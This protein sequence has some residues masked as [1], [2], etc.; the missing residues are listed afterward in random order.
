MHGSWSHIIGNM[1][2]LW[3]FGPEIE[4]AMGRWRYLVFY[5]AG[6][7][8]A[9]I[10]QVAADPHSTAP[11]PG[12]QRGDCRGHG[13][14]SG[15]LSSR[16]DSLGFDHLHVCADHVYPGRASDRLLVSQPVRSMPAQWQMCRP[17]GWRTWRTSAASSSGLSPRACSKTRVESPGNRTWIDFD[18][19]CVGWV[20]R[21]QTFS[22]DRLRPAV[23]GMRFQ[24]RAYVAA[25]G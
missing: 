16:S 5:F 13:R 7:L 24:D 23:P 8:V 4:D 2:F 17:A 3:A 15:H 14:V 11:K 1:I 25:T 19:A 9:M 6:G 10:A 20:A 21:H 12:R 22:R 18:W